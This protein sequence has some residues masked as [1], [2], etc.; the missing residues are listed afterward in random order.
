MRILSLI[1]RILLFYP[2]AV[3][4]SAFATI[5]ETTY[6]NAIYFLPIMSLIFIS[7][8]CIRFFMYRFESR[9]KKTTAF[10][11]ILI[12]IIISV[13]FSILFLKIN[14]TAENVF[15]I[16]LYITGLKAYSH[17]FIEI[18]NPWYFGASVLG[19]IVTAIMLHSETE[20]FKETPFIFLITVCLFMILYNHRNIDVLMQ[21]RNYGKE[22]LP[23]S[24]E[25]L[26][27]N[28]TIIICIFSSL[29]LFFQKQINAVFD[30]V[31]EII[32]KIIK[33]LLTSTN[34][35]EE[36]L[37]N[38]SG[39]AEHSEKTEIITRDNTLLN[40]V[41][42]LIMMTFLLILVIRF[43]HTIAT[44]FKNI[45]IDIINAFSS[46]FKSKTRTENSDPRGYTDYVETIE[47]KQTND[48]STRKE[49]IRKWKKNLKKY[50]SMS[51]GNEKFRFGYMLITFVCRIKNKNITEYDTPCEMSRKF[52]DFD[53]SEVTHIYDP[54]RYGDKKCST[55]NINAMNTALD[56][57]RKKLK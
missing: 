31:W 20:I 44:F 39:S 2:V 55:H 28:F 33:L 50:H 9:H 15:F 13:P 51:D 57:L 18:I 21:K 7:G 40:N 6:T 19:H 12:G 37:P 14:N 48:K 30:F 27:R 49:L 4:L 38:G 26:N 1:W 46:V 53:I 36:V 24:T 23:E 42:M 29:L 5:N 41:F 25:R 10:L 32:K 8:Y 11:E 43:R 17:T 16:I 34:E 3:L 45:L 22:Y 54:I 52:E 47:R 35:P 56:K